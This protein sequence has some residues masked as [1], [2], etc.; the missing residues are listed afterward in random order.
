MVERQQDV[1]LPDGSQWEALS[2]P[3]HLDL[4]Q[5]KDFPGFPF[6]CPETTTGHSA[7]GHPATGHEHSA[8]HAAAKASLF[9]AMTNVHALHAAAIGNHVCPAVCTCGPAFVSVFPFC[10]DIMLC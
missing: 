6:P 3:F 9:E 7:T 8:G 10:V 5:G 4:L 1:D 2:L